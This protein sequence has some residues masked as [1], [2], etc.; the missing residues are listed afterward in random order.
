MYEDAGVSGAKGRD[1]RPAL[2]AMMRDATRRE[3]D[4]VAAW[5][6]GR[7]G[8]STRD[9][10]DTFGDL[11]ALGVALYLHNQAIDTTTSSGRMF[12]TMLG[13]FAE[14]EREMIRERVCAGLVRAKRQGKRLGRRPQHRHLRDRAR[15]LS[16]SGASVRAI[17]RELGVSRS[18][19]HRYTS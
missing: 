11:Q 13:A 15:E 16:A 18:T 14:F 8:R 19:A 10:I 2:D 1:K 9:L 3:F 4:M 5:S 7:L 17:A 6:L 12:F